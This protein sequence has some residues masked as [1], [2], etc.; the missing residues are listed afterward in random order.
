M[1]RERAETFLRLLVETEL[2]RAAARPGDRTTVAGCLTRVMR[3]ARVLTAVEA[4]GDELA[5]QVLDDFELALGVRGAPTPG[6][7]AR[8]L[9]CW[10]GG[11]HQR[12]PPG[13]P[14]RVVPVGQVIPVH[15]EQV[16]GEVT[17]LSY[18]QTQAGALL[19]FVTRPGQLRPVD[20]DGPWVTMPALPGRPA[21]RRRGPVMI[22]YRQFSAADERQ[23]NYQMN[24]HGN[25]GRP[26]Q[27]I[28][29][30]WPD[31]PRNL[32]WLDLTTTPGEPPVRVGLTAAPPAAVTVRRITGSPAEQ[33]LNNLAMRLLVTGAI[34]PQDMLILLTELALER[35]GPLPGT[36][37]GLGDAI[38]ALQ[39]SGA[40]PPASPGPGQL[41]AL[42]ARLNLTGHGITVPPADDLPEPWLGML[43]HRQRT[44][45]Q[46]TPG[47]DGCA[48][49]AV[50][51]PDLAGI[52]LSILGLTAS[53]DG[54]IL[55]TYASG[56]MSGAYHGT[57]E[58]NLAPAI[59]IHDSYGRWHATRVD[60]ACDGDITMRLEVV[61]Q[62]SHGTAWI[63]VI[64]AGSSAEVRTTLPLR[65]Q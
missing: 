10:L 62:L 26:G 8:P 30:L 24:Y 63:E 45:E 37:D 48:A 22:P 52:R 27:W 9:R 12:R 32:N 35:P 31:P 36:V 59:W 15:G 42:C 44:T 13:V 51:L 57:P 47:R 16:T 20:P 64:V 25:G 6:H 33:L 55:H 50:A 17:L 5:G 38:A 1:D 23:T 18:A 2:R 40:L 49:V 34:F 53:A 65:W 46:T 43:R 29:R 61:P 14:D 11:P 56:P 7:P 21:V 19:T 4:L 58:R 3:V 41:A 60:G 54:T 39:A 28:L